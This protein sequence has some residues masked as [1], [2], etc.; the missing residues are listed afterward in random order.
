MKEGRKE[1]KREGRREGLEGRIGRES[2]RK[3]EG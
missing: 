3:K 1:G 2:S